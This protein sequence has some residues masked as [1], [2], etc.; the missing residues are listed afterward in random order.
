MSTA[1]LR[2]RLDRLLTLVENGKD[3]MVRGYVAFVLDIIPP[4]L[5]E[6][7]KDILVI[8]KPMIKKLMGRTPPYRK[9]K[10]VKEIMLYSH[11][12]DLLGQVCNLILRIATNV[13]DI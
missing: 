8:N 5:P 11:R 7:Q 3:G 10:A 1:A 6:I 12:E 2:D 4:T 9:D 13:E